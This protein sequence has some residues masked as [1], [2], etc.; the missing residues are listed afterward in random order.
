VPRAVEIFVY[1]AGAAADE[2]REVFLVRLGPP[3][4]IANFPI[5]R[6]VDGHLGS[7]VRQAR[8]ASLSLFHLDILF[9]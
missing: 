2:L 5:D 3:Q 4:A 9:H 1:P 7:I 8:P 6:V